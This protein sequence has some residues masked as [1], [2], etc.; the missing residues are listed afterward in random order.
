MAIHSTQQ[1]VSNYAA[2][3]AAVNNDG[4]AI[5]SLFEKGVD[6]DAMNSKIGATPLHLAAQRGAMNAL[7]MLIGLNVSVDRLDKTG[8]TAFCVAAAQGQACALEFLASA[9]ANVDASDSEGLTSLHEACNN[10]DL[11]TVRILLDLKA[12]VNIQANLS[13]GATPLHIAASGGG[14]QKDNLYEL[15][16]VCSSA[17]ER[18][19]TKAYHKFALQLH[20]DKQRKVV[21]QTD[22]IV[23]HSDE[24]KMREEWFVRITNAYKILGDKDSRLKYDNSYLNICEVL[25]EKGANPLIKMKNG[26][27]PG[28]VSV[29]C[30]KWGLASLLYDHFNSNLLP[31]SFTDENSQHLNP[32]T[33]K[34]GRTLLHLAVAFGDCVAVKQ[35]LQTSASDVDQRMSFMKKLLYSK[36]VTNS[37]PLLLAASAGNTVITKLLLEKQKSLILC[38]ND[39]DKIVQSDNE[40]KI[41][42]SDI[43]YIDIPD[44]SGQTPL[45]AATCS[46]IATC[47][48]LLIQF[49]ANLVA[50]DNS[51][52]SAFDYSK[53]LG[54]LECENILHK[55]LV[56]LGVP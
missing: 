52:H 40:D 25:L 45:H 41:V 18:E 47:V 17:T 35:I 42:Q 54:F 55:A 37:T 39:E 21:G 2:C 16:G 49:G 11:E 24:V 56:R 3:I 36:D 46:G 14:L 43:A 13:S 33:F 23:G 8:A 28:D 7:K 15:L 4:L 22:K 5:R 6:V 30:R 44:S 38:H 31:G 48:E 27:L 29:Q 32:R 51:C 9:G 19:I 26:L 1:E 20:P 10:G 53:Q 50:K 34:H 12:S